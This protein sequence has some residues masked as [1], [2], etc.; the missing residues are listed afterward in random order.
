MGVPPGRALVRGGRGSL[1]CVQASHAGES[2]RVHARDLAGY[3]RESTFHVGIAH[4]ARRILCRRRHS[5]LGSPAP[6]P[7]DPSA[8]EKIP[9][10]RCAKRK[11]TGYSCW[12]TGNRMI[13]AR[14]KAARAPCA[15][16]TGEARRMWSAVCSLTRTAGRLPGGKMTHGGGIASSRARIPARSASGPSGRIE[17][18]DR[19]EN[20]SKLVNIAANIAEVKGVINYKHPFVTYS[21]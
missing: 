20:D 7:G 5:L 16:C 12:N 18:R 10:L 14:L 6:L 11:E 17:T 13:R 9:R 19:P 4:T 8:S 3:R 2:A 21:L 1:G 15:S